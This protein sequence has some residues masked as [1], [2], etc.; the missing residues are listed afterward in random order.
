MCVGNT[1]R[2]RLEFTTL[3]CKPTTAVAA[4]W[5][6]YTHTYMY[7]IR[8]GWPVYMCMYCPKCKHL[9]CIIIITFTI[10]KGGRSGRIAQYQQL[11]TGQQRRQQQQQ[12]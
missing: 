5:R 2:A 6:K 9:S 1:E 7:Y 10:F 8:V 12:Q 4:A 3:A 11:C